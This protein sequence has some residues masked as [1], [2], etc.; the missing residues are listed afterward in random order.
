MS[1]KTINNARTDRAQKSL[2]RNDQFKTESKEIRKMSMSEKGTMALKRNNPGPLANARVAMRET[3]T[4]ATAVAADFDA[5]KGGPAFVPQNM[6]G[7]EG[8]SGPPAVASDGDGG[9]ERS[10]VEIS[11]GKNLD[12]RDVEE[13]SVA[14][15]SNAI[16]RDW[17]RLVGA[18]MQIARNCAD[19][20]ARLTPAEKAELIATLPFE[21]ATFSKF[22]QISKDSR[23]HTPE[24]QPLLPP[25]YTTV[26]E[27][28]LLKDAEL[29]RAITEKIICPE[30]T[31]EQLLKWRKG[32]HKPETE[33]AERDQLKAER[34]HQIEDQRTAWENLCRQQE[35]EKERLMREV[36]AREQ[37]YS[38]LCRGVGREPEPFSPPL[39]PDDGITAAEDL[40]RAL[41]LLL[42]ARG[43]DPKADNINKAM[44]DFVNAVLPRS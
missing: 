11:P 2:S 7:L 19:A 15:Y 32:L 10:A 22:V 29:H 3:A 33:Q 23:L 6:T 16:N 4:T 36:E 18:S 24:V 30:M 44:T 31:R 5:S 13:F 37:Q 38:D 25:Y 39:A 14:S 43:F 27:I 20:D 8:S 42:V 41:Q 28:T 17:Q 21:E 26:Y 1:S 35:R 9:I 12:G 34:R 40:E